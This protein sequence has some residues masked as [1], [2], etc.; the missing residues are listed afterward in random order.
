MFPRHF[1][2]TYIS[3]S[4]HQPYFNSIFLVL[5]TD[6]FFVYLRLFSCIG[7]TAINGRAVCRL[8]ITKDV[9]RSIVVYYATIAAFIS[10]T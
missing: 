2:I 6:L 3:V 8:F 7:Y 4:L 1:S 10:S 9:E 5:L